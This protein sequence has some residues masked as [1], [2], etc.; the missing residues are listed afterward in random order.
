MSKGV[1]IFLVI[2]SLCGV[3][4]VGAGVA[5]V[6]W[7]K[8]NFKDIEAGMKEGIAEAETFA[9][10]TDQH[11]CEQEALR[12]VGP[13]SE[14]D[15]ICSA[16]VALFLSACLH[17]AEPTPGL[18]DG[19]PAKDELLRSAAWVREQCAEPGEARTANR[20]ALVYQARQAYCQEA[21][22][23]ATEPAPA[24]D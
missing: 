9:A 21:P 4:V 5:G 10:S 8:A 23:D 20:C 6:M 17:H 15:P 19:V 22:S 3:A 18:C 13:C 24:E 1:K 16:K 7:F 2:L 12:R 14:L 11:G